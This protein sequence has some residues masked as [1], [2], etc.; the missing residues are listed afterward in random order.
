M[1][2]VRA[3][4]DALRDAHRLGRKIHKEIKPYADYGTGRIEEKAEELGINAEKVR[5]LRQFADPEGGYTQQELRE[6]FQLCRKERRALGL[7]F[8]IKFLTIPKE[9][10]QRAEFQRLVIEQR[11]NCT[12]VDTEIRARFGRRRRGGNRPKV[13]DTATSLLSQLDAMCQRWRRLVG[14][15]TDEDDV[16]TAHANVKELPAEVQTDLKQVSRAITRLHAKVAEA[17]AA[18]RQRR[19]PGRRRSS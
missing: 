16:G 10:G 14:I 18:E 1:D 13:P 4:I 6:L 15:M 17:L 5:K 8:M 12:R 7:S 19:R 11:W 9:G 2:A 3:A